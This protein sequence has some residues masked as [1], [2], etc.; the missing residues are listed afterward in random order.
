MK[1]LYQIFKYNDAHPKDFI[2]LV[3]SFIYKVDKAKIK[4]LETHENSMRKKQSLLQ[5]STEV[6]VQMLNK[7][8]EMET[9]EQAMNM[10][11]DVLIKEVDII[12][13]LLK[14]SKI[15]IEAE[16][17]KIASKARAESRKG[18]ESQR[19]SG[20]ATSTFWDNSD[21]QIAQKLQK[22]ENDEF[23]RIKKLRYEFPSL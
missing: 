13:G 15:E 7:I 9:N 6:F 1:L 5:S 17:V 11:W 16:M 8:M 12:V 18:H 10:N 20:R 3:Q 2:H 22:E 19:G 4:T 14:A 21:S 23:A